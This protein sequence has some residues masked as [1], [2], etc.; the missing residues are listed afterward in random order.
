MIDDSRLPFLLGVGPPSGVEV[1]APTDTSQHDANDQVTETFCIKGCSN[2]HKS[3]KSTHDLV[4]AK[5]GTRLVFASI[6][7]KAA[8]WAGAFDSECVCSGV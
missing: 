8:S 4:F 3:V 5:G 2:C 6:T 1:V 7:I